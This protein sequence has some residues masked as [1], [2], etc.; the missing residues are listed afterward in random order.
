MDSPRI[1]WRKN[2]AKKCLK[3]T[4]ADRLTEENAK[5]AVK[6]WQ[7][8]FKSYPKEKI[9]LLWDCNKMTGYDPSARNIWQSALKEMKN[10]IDCIWLI[11]NSSLIKMGATFMSVFASYPIN[12]VKTEEEIKI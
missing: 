7:D 10:Q 6:I 3:F 9:V 4:F 11:T 8:S 2:T 1:E 5:T 12:V